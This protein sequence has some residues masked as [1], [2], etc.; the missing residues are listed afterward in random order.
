MGPIFVVFGPP[1]LEL[2]NKIPSMF[3]MLSL[4]ELL[5]IGFMTSFDLPVHLR[6]AGWYVFVKSRTE[7]SVPH[8]CEAR[9]NFPRSKC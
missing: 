2:S 7:F 1:S 4:V 6:A 3:E 5:G 9:S 8:A